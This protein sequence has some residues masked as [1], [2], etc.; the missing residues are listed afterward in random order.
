V[1]WNKC[2]DL[3]SCPNLNCYVVWKKGT[4]RFHDQF[5]VICGIEQMIEDDDM[6]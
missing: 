4:G 2:E 1:D 6:T 3:L 5:E